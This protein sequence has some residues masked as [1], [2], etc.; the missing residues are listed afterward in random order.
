MCSIV[1][2][3]LGLKVGSS[4]FSAYQQRQQGKYAKGVAEYNAR[5][6]ENEAVSVREVGAERESLLRTQT[7]KLI[8]TQRTQLA[9]S[10]VQ[11]ESG[12]PLKLQEDTA[13]MGEA[14]ALRVR[15]NFE[16]RAKAIETG[17]EFTREQ[18][19]YADIAS[20]RRAAGTLL[21]GGAKI[22]TSVLGSGLADKWFTDKSANVA[23]DAFQP[24]QSFYSR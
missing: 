19:E 4:I 9:A 24:S 13:I 22:G 16:R 1:G 5:I 3:S 2:I 14:D 6:S 17:A 18:G 8:S 12:A 20:K 10:G 11:L 7:A 23:G 21:S 15:G